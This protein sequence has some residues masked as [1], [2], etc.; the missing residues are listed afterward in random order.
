LN[1]LKILRKGN[2][3][4]LTTRE[5]ME[6]LPNIENRCHPVVSSQNMMGALMVY[7]NENMEKVVMKINLND[8]NDYLKIQKANSHRNYSK[9][10]IGSKR[11][12][13]IGNQTKSAD[14]I[15]NE[16]NKLTKKGLNKLSI[17]FAE[18]HRLLNK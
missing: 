1:H 12:I 10:S 8:S 11:T 5:D 17:F 15:V 6:R 3:E 7:T 2:G 18:N 16:T 13:R 9:K 14:I 4:G